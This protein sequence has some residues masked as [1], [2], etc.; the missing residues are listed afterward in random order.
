VLQN[1]GM[2]QTANVILLSPDYKLILQ[3]RDDRPG[4]SCPGQITAFGGTCEK[5][6]TPLEAA[7]REMKEELGLDL[8]DGDLTFWKV[9]RKT[10][11]KHGEDSEVNLFA[12][13]YPL[14]P[15]ELTVYEGQ[16]YVLVSADDDFADIKLTRAAQDFVRDFFKEH[17][18]L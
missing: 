14:R 4:I 7:K 5:N 1:E 9:Y 11:A 16:G 6:E 17:P 13:N 10:L 12:L 2:L 15:E 8:Q 18:R 3:L